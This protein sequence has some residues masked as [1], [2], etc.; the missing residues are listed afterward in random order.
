QLLGRT[1]RHARRVRADRLGRDRPDAARI[2]SPPARG[3]RAS[4]R[5]AAQR[6]R[7][8]GRRAAMRAAILYGPEDLRVEDVPEP[9]G[10][11]IIE[12]QAAT[13]CGTD[14]KMWRHGHPMLPPY[15]CS[16]GHETAGVRTDEGAGVLVS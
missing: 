3:H 7:P 5:A 16:F 12:V 10:E 11:V 4:A 1:G 9:D 15:P 14:V 2:A 6:R 8:E 13:T